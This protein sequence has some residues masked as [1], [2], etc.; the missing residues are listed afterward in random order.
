MQNYTL[1]KAAIAFALSSLI[2]I[3]LWACGLLR[4]GG[5]VVS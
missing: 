3:A 2:V 1:T 5:A 4:V